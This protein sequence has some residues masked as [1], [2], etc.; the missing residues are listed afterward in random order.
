LL[1]NQ[2]AMDKYNAAKEKQNEIIKEQESIPQSEYE[3]F[4]SEQDNHLLN[5]FAE[6]KK[7]KEAA[8]RQ[9]VFLELD[10]IQE[11]E[12]EEEEETPRKRRK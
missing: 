8:S 3:Q 5:K 12:E 7:E 10:N 2:D 11:E 1:N 4:M 6:W 9:S